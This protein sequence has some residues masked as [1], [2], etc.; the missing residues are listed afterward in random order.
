[1]IPIID[2]KKIDLTN[3]YFHSFIPILLSARMGNLVFLYTFIINCPGPEIKKAFW[4]FQSEG[5]ED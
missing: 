3:C 4:D 5:Q 2:E 1:M